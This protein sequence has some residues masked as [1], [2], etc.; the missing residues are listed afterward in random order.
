MPIAQKK[1]FEC[2]DKTLVYSEEITVKLWLN[3][4]TTTTT[5]KPNDGLDHLLGKEVSKATAN[6]GE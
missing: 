2:E 3:N 4:T 5:R 1:E 6:K